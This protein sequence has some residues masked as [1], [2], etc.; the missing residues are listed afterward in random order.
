[1]RVYDGANWIAA[2]SAGNVSLI[3]Y[4]Y[5][6]TSNQT[7]FSGSD[8]NSATLSYTVDNLQVVMNGIVLDPSDFTATNG[9]SVVLAA[10]AATGDLINIYAFKSFTTADMVSKTNGGT[11]A[12]AV[13]FDA[14]ANFG[15]NDKAQFGA[16]NDLQ[17]YHD[18][19]NSIIKEN[20][21]GDL[22]LMGTN[23][24][25]KNGANSATYLT[26]SSGGA[27]TAFH[28]NSAKIAT[29][30]S[31]VDIT[32]GFTAT[33]GCTITTADNSAQLCR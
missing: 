28:N 16:G 10:G 29:S 24:Q 2:T 32:G 30:S 12:G 11:F 3:L 26:A 23:V 33:D 18:G 25:M 13:T 22:F 5:T 14:G 31:G 9:T 21:T 6:A 20:S 1:M 17:I 19:S 4:E 27:V 7:T 15:D 8:D